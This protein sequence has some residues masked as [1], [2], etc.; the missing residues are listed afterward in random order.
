M[1]WV[2]LHTGAACKQLEWGVAGQGKA[3]NRHRR[4]TGSFWG[5]LYTSL[6]SE[7][8]QLGD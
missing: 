4:F 7:L 8:R 1:D 3:A 5:V 6:L 2:V